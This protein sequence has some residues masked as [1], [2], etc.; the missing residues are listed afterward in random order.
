M[1]SLSN[2]E[3]TTM[4]SKHPRHPGGGGANFNTTL[5]VTATIPTLLLT[6]LY[7]E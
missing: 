5:C 1:T 3:E 7:T 2:V 4:Q 6:R